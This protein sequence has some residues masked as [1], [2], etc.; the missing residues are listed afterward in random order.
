VLI[1]RVEPLKEELK[2]F[3]ECV[4]AG[5]PFPITPAQAVQN[6]KIAESSGWNSRGC[7]D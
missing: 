5:K 7:M 3:V 6:L 4:K 1:N 2:T